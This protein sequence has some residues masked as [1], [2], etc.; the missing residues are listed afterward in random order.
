KTTDYTKTATADDSSLKG[1]NYKS[2][3]AKINDVDALI[4]D[5]LNK[6]NK[7]DGTQASVASVSQISKV[8]FSSKFSNL[9]SEGN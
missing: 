6:L 2:A 8:D 4:T 7:Y 9:L 1:D 5:Y 3:Q